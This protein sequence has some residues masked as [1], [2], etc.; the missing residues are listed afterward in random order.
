MLGNV[1]ADILI[2]YIDEMNLS[3]KSESGEKHHKA[4]R[5]LGWKASNR[6]M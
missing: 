1:N 4:F 2:R 5:C 3:E 6:L